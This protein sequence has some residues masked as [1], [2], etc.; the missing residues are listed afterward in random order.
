M[1]EH[2]K[3]EK[4]WQKRWKKEGV[5]DSEVEEGKKKFF[6][7]F[8][9]PGVSGYQHVGHMRGY[10]YTDIIAR[11]KRMKGYNVLFPVGVHATGNK[12]ITFA[13]KIRNRKEKWI[14]YVTERGY[15]QDEIEKLEDPKKVV[16]Y[17]N[18]TYMNKWEKFGFLYD[19]RRFTCTIHPDYKKFIEW[20]FKKLKE[21]DLLEQGS[22][23]ATFCPECGPV[24]V[25]PNEADISEGGTAEK[26]NYTLL[27][28]KFGDKYLVAA[29]LRPETVFGQTNLW[30]NP[31]IT[32]KEV[33]AGGETWVMSGKAAEKL[34]YQKDDVKEIGEIEGEELIG[35][36]AEA[37][38]VDHK[39]IILPAEFC[40]PNMGTGIVTSV[41]SDAPYDY[42]ALKELQ[43]DEGLLE[44]YDLNPERI[45]NIDPIPI[46]K[47]E[48]YGKFPAVE[49]TEKMGITSQEQEEKLEKATEKIYEVGFHT[50]KMRDNC[51]K[52][53]GMPVSV[54]KE[55]VKEDL[56][57]KGEADVFWDLSEKVVC[58]CGE[59]VIIKRLDD[60]WF[61]RY[62]DKELT[63]TSKRYVREDMEVYPDEYHKNLPDVLEWFKNRPCVRMGK[64]LGT[65]FPFD[66]KWKIEPISDSTIY[67]AYYTISH[68]IDENNIEPGKLTEEFFD[69]VFLGKRSLKKVSESTGIDKKIIKESRKEFKYWY[70]VN[71]NLGG[72]EHKTVHFPAYI[73]NHVGLLPRENW[74]EGIFVNWWVTGKGGKISK[75]K[76]GAV[77]LP[78]VMDKYSVDGI[79][80]YY[81]HKGNPHTDIVWDPENAIEYKHSMDNIFEKL[82]NLK[83]REKKDELDKWMISRIYKR[84][85]GANKA[86]ENYEIRKYTDAVFFK[87]HEDFKWYLRRRK[88]N[89]CQREVIETWARLMA[90]IT[91]HHCEEV[92]ERL[93]KENFI[94][95]A[96]LPNFKKEKIERKLEAG[97][98]LIKSTLEDIRNILGVIDIEEPEKI[99]LFVA[100][101]W[102]RKLYQKFKKAVGENKNFDKIKGEIMKEKEFRKQGGK[103][104]KIIRKLFEKPSRLSNQILKEEKEYLRKGKKIFKETFNSEVEIILEKD[105]KKRKAKKALP[106]KPAILVK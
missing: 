34:K 17:F 29:T 93:G 11:Y 104:I 53:A 88:E 56:I 94:T 1:V 90:P 6:I 42:I 44:R 4:K 25:E 3:I 87:I 35:K 54:A 80:L 33:E 86:M 78:D 83:I 60:Q 43:G 9:Y 2:R 64:W 79:R 75:S 14:K 59:R 21:N 98:E 16:E 38:K 70:P 13:Q 57:E 100:R 30:V 28:F 96:E 63:E 61:I 12:P 84:V 27:K 8:A 24:A 26:V 5:R 47:S 7:H 76:G 91:P 48:D 68:I 89:S 32:Y 92:W 85:K 18:K 95:N 49:I 45:E 37:P 51:G 101:P 72:K 46:I 52:Y 62:S 105:A 20:Q 73:M 67:S 58:R 22:Y 106:S 97:E 23:Y 55:R 77:P 82:L 74:P 41:P 36:T 50:G 81:A 103:V 69:Y 15:P 40:D 71:I 65:D 66:D 10:T 99:T 19:K 31:E 102:K 39:L